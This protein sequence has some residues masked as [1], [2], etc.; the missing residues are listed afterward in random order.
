MGGQEPDTPSKM[1][2]GEQYKGMVKRA[3]E[4]ADRYQARIK[5]QASMLGE[6][7]AKQVVL[8]DAL[9]EIMKHEEERSNKLGGSWTLA[10]DAL[11]SVGA[12]KGDGNGHG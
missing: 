5:A 3:G 7:G 11:D 9:R 8:I 2:S 1:V 4:Q 6:V 12:L 10:R